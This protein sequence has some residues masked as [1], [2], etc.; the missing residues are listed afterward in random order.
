MGQADRQCFLCHWM[1]SLTGAVGSLLLNS[2]VSFCLQTLSLFRKTGT[3]RQGQV[4]SEV[5]GLC[6]SLAARKPD[7]FSDAA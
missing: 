1:K 6:G 4:G 5:P 3:G 7:R 2:S